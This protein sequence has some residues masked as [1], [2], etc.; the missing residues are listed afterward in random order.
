MGILSEYRTA[1]AM[2]AGHQ[3]QMA[4]TC[5]ME[6]GFSLVELMVAATIGAMLLAGLVQVAAGARSSFRQQEAIGELQERARFT[7]ARLNGILRQAGFSAQPWS[8]SESPDAVGAWGED[9]VRAH[10]D[11]VRLRTWSDRNCF[12]ELNPFS[13]PSGL[14]AFHLKETVLELN[15]SGNVALTC[16]YGPDPDHLTTQINRQG[17]IP[18]AESVQALFA[19]DSDGDGAADRWMRGGGWTDPALIVGVQLAVLLASREVVAPIATVSHNV[20]DHVVTTRDGR[21]R[22]V[23]TVAQAFRGRA[24]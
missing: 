8:A 4:G 23:V 13:G 15:A 1:G 2:L 10:G 21:L 9:G 17:V 16:R 20:L 24:P 7:A 6:R 3:R 11:R 5:Q 19:E 22:R 12:G 14:P 18:G